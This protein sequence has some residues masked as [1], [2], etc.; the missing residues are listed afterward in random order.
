MNDRIRRRSRSGVKTSWRC[1]APERIVLF[2]AFLLLLVSPVCDARRSRTQQRQQ[3]GRKDPDDYYGVLGVRK[4]ASSKE[5]K[6]AYR[7]LALDFHPDKVQD[8]DKKEEAQKRFM[9]VQQ[10]YDVL[11][12]DDK[13]KIYDDYGKQGLEMLERGQDPREYGGSFGGNFGG[14]HGGGFQHHGGGFSGGPEFSQFFQGFGGP[15]GF[16]GGGGGGFNQ[17]FQGGGGPGAH[18]QF[19]QQG[20][21]AGGGRGRSSH[22]HGGGR[23]PADLFPKG[24]KVT[25]LGSPKFPDDSSKYLWLVMF[26]RNDDRTVQDLKPHLE[27]LVNKVKGNFKVGALDCG[28]N[29]KEYRYCERAHGLDV[30]EELPAFAFVV[31]GELSWYEGDA[32]YVP[33]AKPLYE[34]AMENMPKELIVNINQPTQ[35][36]S[37]LLEPMKQH[38]RFI[39][40]ILLLTDK[41]ETSALYFSLAYHHR[42]KFLFGESRGKSLNLAKEFQ[43]KRYPT[44]VAI[45]P[46]SGAK[47]PGST[48][49]KGDYLTVRY[50][51][52]GA[53]THDAL[54]S[55]IEQLSKTTQRQR[56]RS[57]GSEL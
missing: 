49:Y 44:L 35:V 16:P 11:S 48:E 47:I 9:E 24:G 53:L 1:G 7:K 55:W 36:S 50:P 37:K 28:M 38:A 33:T 22:G 39:G 30:D 12:D 23:P 4:T 41:Y 27:T 17:F 3:G 34:F 52:D 26:Y 29:D 13:R 15:G 25:K 20:F 46:K 31:N 19:F 5:I 14:N 57:A 21:G 56:R 40:T 43:V 51:A 8:P 54:S 18:Q 10:A 2:T 32:E 6:S 45:I 42:S